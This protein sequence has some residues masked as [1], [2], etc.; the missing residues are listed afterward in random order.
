MNSEVILKYDFRLDLLL[1]SSK[2]PTVNLR[3]LLPYS[4]N[5]K[6]LWRQK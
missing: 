2:L 4:S 6:R 5:K 3:V 1:W